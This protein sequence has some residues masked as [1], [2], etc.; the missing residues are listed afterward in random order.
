MKAEK[1]TNGSDPVIL[2]L[3]MLNKL[4]TVANMTANVTVIIQT[5]QGALGLSLKE[6][7][8]LGLCDKSETVT[9]PRGTYN[10]LLEK[11]YAVIMETQF[12]YPILLRRIGPMAN[13]P[14]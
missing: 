2:P 11:Y 4:I 8:E 1:V 10:W 9:V 5:P 3:F 14:Q 6:C 12:V 7:V 13:L